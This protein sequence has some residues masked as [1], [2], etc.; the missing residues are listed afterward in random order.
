MAI[1]SEERPGSV[2]CDQI[3]DLPHVQ[4]ALAQLRAD[5][6]N[7]GKLYVAMV[8]KIDRRHGRGV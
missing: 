2:L 3:A 5:S 4:A 7:S 6:I 8:D 1:N